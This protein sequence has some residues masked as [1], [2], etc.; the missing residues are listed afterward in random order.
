MINSVLAEYRAK[1][2]DM[3]LREFPELRR[4]QQQYE[5]ARMQQRQGATIDNLL[6][7]LEF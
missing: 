3:A 2:L 5:M 4:F 6:Q 7:T 1:S